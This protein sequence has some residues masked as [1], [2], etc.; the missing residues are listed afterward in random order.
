MGLTLGVICRFRIDPAQLLESN[1]DERQS[2]YQ[3]TADRHH[4]Y[5]CAPFARLRDG[6]HSGFKQ[7]YDHP[8]EIQTHSDI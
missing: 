3:I 8:D 2:A 7:V 6:D 1:V 5:D 4:I